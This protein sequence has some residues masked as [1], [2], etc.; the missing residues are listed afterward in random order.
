MTGGTPMVAHAD[1]E[2]VTASNPAAPGEKLYAYLTGLG[3]T[4]PGVD[5]G[6]A[7]PPSPRA[8][9]NSPIQV[10]V[11]GNAA[12]VLVAVGFPGGVDTY[13]L[14]FQVPSET[15]SGGA[16]LQVSAAWIEGPTVTIPIQ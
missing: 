9:V 1:N 16:L 13:Q 3:P 8:S 4:N 2:M 12:L 6:Q 10:T 15:R 7:F 11:N 14:Q 5:P